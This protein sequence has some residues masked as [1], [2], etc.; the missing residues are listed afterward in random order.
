VLQ[1]YA[2]VENEVATVAFSIVELYNDRLSIMTVVVVVGR[3]KREMHVTMKPLTGLL[4]PASSETVRLCKTSLFC[5]LMFLAQLML[6]PQPSVSRIYYLFS[7]ILSDTMDQGFT[8]P[9]FP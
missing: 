1:F 2:S 6:F 5:F 9:E 4:K 7:V 8:L 3:R